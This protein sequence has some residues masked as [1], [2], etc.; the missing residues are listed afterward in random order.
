M[1]PI[2]LS[3][4]A[5]EQALRR[6]ATAEEIEATIREGKWRP[7]FSGRLEAQRRFAYNAVWN[8]RTYAEKAVRPVF[9]AESAEIVVVTVYVYYFD[10]ESE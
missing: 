5:R 7:A 3:A 6:G 10:G 8:G 4:H 2:R 1:K 9:V